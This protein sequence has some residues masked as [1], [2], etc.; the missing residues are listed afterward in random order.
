MAKKDKGKAIIK[1]ISFGE[2]DKM[3]L[4]YLEKQTNSSA[5][6]RNLI[7]KDMKEK[8]LSTN[9]K[10]NNGLQ[11]EPNPSEKEIKPN[12]VDTQTG[13]KDTD[14]VYID[15]LNILMPRIDK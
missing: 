3:L 6:I 4:E 7:E 13:K 8:N 14:S 10:E 12:I 1:T 5:Y 9:I 11:S 15:E 2:E